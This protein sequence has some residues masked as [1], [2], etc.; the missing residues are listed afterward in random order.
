MNIS[1]FRPHN[2]YGPNMGL[3]HVVPQFIMEFLKHND[4][5]EKASI[6][7]K[8]SLKAV[9][10]FCFVQDIVKGIQLLA[11]LNSGVNVYNLG[12]TK[13]LSMKELLSEISLI[14][15]KDYVISENSDTHF[16]GT[17]LRCPDIRKAESIGF[18]PEVEI[19]EG[20]KHTID[21]YKKNYSTLTD[22]SNT[23]Y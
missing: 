14:L 5:S 18:L 3:K 8:G 22:L 20:L 16:G 11:K 12:N 23:T 15:K 2:V 1:I 17:R 13:T 4:K 6:N 9:R 19:Q 7:V 21:W 10:A